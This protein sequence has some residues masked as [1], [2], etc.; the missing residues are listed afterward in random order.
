MTRKRDHPYVTIT[1]VPH[2]GR[3]VRTLRIPRPLLDASKALLGALLV[4]SLW[5]V[6]AY[7]RTNDGLN[8]VLAFLQLQARQ[9]DVLERAYRDAESRYAVLLAEAQGIQQDLSQLAAESLEIRRM[10]VEADAV[11]P[12]ALPAPRPLI[13]DEPSVGRGGP[14]GHLEVGQVVA[15]TLRYADEQVREYDDHIRALRAT[16]LEYVR[17]RAHT[18]TLW[19]AEGWISSPFGNRRHPV[20]GQPDRHT[21]IDIA[22]RVGAPVL[23]AADGTV[24]EAGRKGGYGLAVVINHGYGLRTLYGH[25][26]RITVRVGQ[27]V[28]KGQRIGSMGSTG[29][30]TG[31]HLHYEIML[32]G[33]AV[34]PLNY[35]P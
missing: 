21:G 4:I 5:A 20:T 7:L 31:P 11:P 8:E 13:A 3:S 9:Y 18:P 28:T 33:K 30:S 22:G 15:T 34:N 27:R 29:L 2:D 6:S 26:S 10:L 1:I 32:Q 24:I 14:A 17:R 35:L 16:T 19:P 25:L 23:S 12:P